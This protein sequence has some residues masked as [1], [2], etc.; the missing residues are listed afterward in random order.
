MGL[1]LTAATPVTVGAHPVDTLLSV[2][3]GVPKDVAW[4]GNTVRSMFRDR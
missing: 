4:Q 3:V 1:T 2:N